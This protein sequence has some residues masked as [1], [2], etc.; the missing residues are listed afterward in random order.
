MY[1][2]FFLV[3]FLAGLVCGY[4]L[5]APLARARERYQQRQFKPRLIKPYTPA[6]KA[7]AGGPEL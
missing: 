2:T 4:L 1:L 3:I 6:P 5:H 7:G